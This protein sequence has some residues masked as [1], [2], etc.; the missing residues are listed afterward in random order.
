M[1]VQGRME[2]PKRERPVGRIWKFLDRLF[3]VAYEG[4]KILCKHRK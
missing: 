3:L 4:P 2:A 1:G